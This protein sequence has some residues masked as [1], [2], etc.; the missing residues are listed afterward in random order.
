MP[1]DPHPSSA[2][3]DAPDGEVIANIATV[4]ADPPPH[5]NKVAGL[6]VLDP[7]FLIYPA[8]APRSFTLLVLINKPAP[9]VPILY[10]PAGQSQKPPPAAATALIAACTAAVTSILPI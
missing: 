10:E 7:P 5:E 9:P 2:N 8:P 3:N 6:L 4:G 1:V